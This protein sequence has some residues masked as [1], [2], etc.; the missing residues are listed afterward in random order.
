MPLLE[1]SFAKLFG[2][3]ERIESGTG[4]ESLRM[5][6]NKPVFMFH[7]KKVVGKM[8]EMFKMLHKLSRENHP[9]AVSCCDVARGSRAPDGLTTGHA[10]TLL[11]VIELNGEKLAKVRNPWSKERYNGP[12]SDKDSRWTPEL[13]KKAGHTNAN[14]GA[15]FLPFK[16]FLS[17]P[18]FRRTDVAIYK[19]FASTHTYPVTQK[20]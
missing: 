9:M 8:D 10:Y 11:D 17:K 6:T 1:K 14:D 19:D 4:Y 13:L 18:Y 20:T 5:L 15:F 7:H 2:S 16:N 3:Y 12:W